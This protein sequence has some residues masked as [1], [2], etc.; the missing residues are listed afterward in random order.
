L[1]EI[2]NPTSAAVALDDYYI[3]DNGTYV[4]L[5]SGGAWVP[6]G[7]D[8][9]SDFLG[10]FPAGSSIPA[11]GYIVIGFD[12][13]Y[14]TEFG[15]CPDFFV[16]EA[17]VTCGG[18]T[19]PALLE[20]EPGSIFDT[21]TLSNNREMLVLFTWSGDTNDILQDVDY[22]T[23]G[24]MFEAGSRVDKSAEPGYQPDTP[25]DMQ[26]GAPVPMPGSSIERCGVEAG[27]TTMGGNGITGHDET[28]ENFALSFVVQA[29]PT[30]GAVNGCP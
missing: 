26:V 9:Q 20:T 21:A 16:A 18:N 11:G 6:E 7:D 1:V 15:A 25:V 28:S 22:V 10:R 17:D 4:D 8:N 29:M 30:P 5:A 14:E 19:V 3:S 23:W 12:P 2:H 24:D 13:E 27:E